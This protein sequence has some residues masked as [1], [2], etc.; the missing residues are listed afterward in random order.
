MTINF[1]NIKDIDVTTMT[2]RKLNNKTAFDDMVKCDS[3]IISKVK[4]CFDNEGL[5]FYFEY[6]KVIKAIYLF[7]V[8]DG[9]ARCYY[10]LLS[11]DIDYDNIDYLEEA[12]VDDLKLLISNNKVNEIIWK[13]NV[14]TPKKFDFESYKMPL[15]ICSVLFGG[16]LGY[17]IN[18]FIL[19]ILFGFG[20]GLLGSYSL[21]K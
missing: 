18:S 9:V 21:K 16:V 7:E 2:K 5:V 12:L 19:G 1:K 11:K 13:D 4:K 10:E 15:I 17:A 3:K 20:L 8:K 14:I 6:K